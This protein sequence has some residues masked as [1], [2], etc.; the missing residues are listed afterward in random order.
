MKSCKTCAGRDTCVKVCPVVEKRL[1]KDET[2]KD[3]HIEV[4]VGGFEFEAMIERRS[5]EM[6]RQ[7]E[8][9]KKRVAVELSM[10]SKRE[11]R[12]VTLIAS[13]LS[14]REAASR[15]KISRYTL[16]TLVNRASAKLSVAHFAHL[17]RDEK[18]NPDKSG[19]RL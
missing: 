17:V 12:A 15:M 8:V 2:G 14:Q 3:T 11:L 18:A 9:I 16:R 4:N 10:L 13:G 7:D 19:G 1:P 6:W 5:F